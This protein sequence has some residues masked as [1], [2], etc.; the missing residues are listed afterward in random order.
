M[1][2]KEF[3]QSLKNQI[4]KYDIFFYKFIVEQPFYQNFLLFIDNTKMV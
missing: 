3:S 1:F 4:K 2:F